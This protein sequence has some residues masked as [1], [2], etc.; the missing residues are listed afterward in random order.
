MTYYITDGTADCFYTAVF[1]AYKDK[2][3]VITSET[4]VQI[5]LGC[6]MKEVRA[7]P[8]KA[9]RVRRRLASYDGRALNDVGLILRSCDPL[10]EQTAFVYIRLTITHG[11]AVRGMQANPRVLQATDTIRKVTNELH[12]LKGF[13]RFMEN[14]DGVLYAPCSPDNDVI[15]LLAKHFAE[16][17]GARSFVIHDVKRKTAALC[18]GK[19]IVMTRVGDAQI[20]LSESEIYFT[21]LWKQYYKSVNIAARP[22]EKQ[23]KGYMPVRYW[24]FLPEKN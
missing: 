22:H 3:C 11:G 7:V 19:Q 20:Y 24:K 2:D 21:E 12:K 14:G 9:G 23:M 6:E 8:E 1:D 4:D 18:D 15:D 17:L 5:G 10:K 16:R 13:L